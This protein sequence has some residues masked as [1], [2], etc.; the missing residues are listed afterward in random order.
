MNHEGNVVY[1]TT[2]LWL[3]YLKVKYGCQV[4]KLQVADPLLK[5]L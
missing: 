1:F 3:P 5:Q 4:A 2:V